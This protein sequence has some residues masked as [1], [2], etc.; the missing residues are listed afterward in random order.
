MLSFS[1]PGPG[2]S[3][4][5]DYF[6]RDTVDFDSQIAG[7]IDSRVSLRKRFASDALVLQAFAWAQPSDADAFRAAVAACPQF[8]ALYDR[9]L[10][11]DVTDDIE[12]EIGRAVSQ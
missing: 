2:D 5:P 10:R 1:L 7:L 4:P 8:A 6:A 11:E 9:L 12:A 3:T